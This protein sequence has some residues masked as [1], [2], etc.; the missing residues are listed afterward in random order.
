MHRIRPYDAGLT[1]LT[2][3]PSNDWS[4]PSDHATAAF[5]VATAFGLN[6]LPGRAFVLF[7]M[8]FMIG[9]SRIFV[10]THYLT[11]VLGGAATGICTA[12][13]VR[14]AYREGSRLDLLA[15]RIL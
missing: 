6:D 2:I 8:A 3:A 9:W 12:V 14:V 4:F 5:G 7:V 10:G 13:L 1:Y 11:D 15:T